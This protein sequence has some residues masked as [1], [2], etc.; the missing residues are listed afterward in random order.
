[1]NRRVRAREVFPLVEFLY[2]LKPAGCCWHVMLD[3]GNLDCVEGCARSATKSGHPECVALVE[4][5]LK[6]SITQRRKL[7]RML[8][9]Q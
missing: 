3:D 1:M 8:Y 2:F 7:Y 5:L 6:M 4:P 9:P